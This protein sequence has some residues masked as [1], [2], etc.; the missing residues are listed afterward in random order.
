MF[1]ELRSYKPSS[2]VCT[3]SSQPSTS[4]CTVYSTCE[5]RFGRTFNLQSHQKIHDQTF[6]DS[7][8]VS[9]FA[10]NYPTFPTTIFM[11]SSEDRIVLNFNDLYYVCATPSSL[12]KCF[13]RK[14]NKNISFHKL[15]KTFMCII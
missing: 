15:F 13:C 8:L 10:A 12:P 3:H 14:G 2:R 11:A 6:T 9:I 1:R 5:I 7:H 4:A